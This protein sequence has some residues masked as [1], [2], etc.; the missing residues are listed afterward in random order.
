[1]NICLFIARKLSLSTGKKTSP[2]VNVAMAAVAISVAVMLASIAIVLG[3]KNQIKERIIGFNSH[4]TLYSPGANQYDPESNI[5]TLDNSLCELLDSLPYVTSYNLELSMPV[6]FKTDHDFKGV[7]IKGLGKGADVSNLEESLVEGRMPDFGAKPS[8][9]GTGEVLISSIAANQLGLKT[10]DF[11]NT[12]FITDDVRVRRLK[13][14]GIYNTHFE[15]YDDVFVYGQLAMLQQIAGIRHNQG[16]AVKIMTD[17]FDRLEANTQDL[18]NRLILATTTGRLGKTYFAENAI[19]QGANYF[20]WLNLLD[21]NVIVVLVLMLCVAAITLISGMLIIIIDKTR[22]IGIIRSLGM[23]NGRLSRVFVYMALRVALWGLLIGNAVM[24]TLIAV[25]DKTRFIPL[26]GEAYYFD[27][28]P[29]SF[30]LGAFLLLN[31][32][33]VVVIFLTLLLPARFVSR[34]S[35]ARAMRYE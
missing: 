9:D 22:F 13:I 21:T 5:S 31:I 6:I 18:H 11:I 34:I 19:V 16:T 8:S 12:Y 29:V 32:G 33:T 28:V 30:D 4:I 15:H 35:P 1:M 17:D 23:S 27:Y 26:D 24:L 20:Q 10:G 14:T 2:A 7:Y 3:F 25:Q